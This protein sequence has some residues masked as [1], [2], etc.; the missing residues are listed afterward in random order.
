MAKR[1]RPSSILRKIAMAR[2]RAEPFAPPAAAHAETFVEFVNRVRPGY[3][4]HD[5][6]RKLAAVL[7]D[8]A[9]GK[10]KRVMIFMPPRHSKSETVSRLFSAYYVS[11]FPDRFVGITSYSA[12]LAYTLSRAAKD[13]YLKGGG[14]VRDDVGAVKHWETSHG[15]GMWAAGVGGAITGK[16]FHLGIIDDA[17]KNAEEA[18]SEVIRAKHKEWYG[19]T[20][21][22]REQPGDGWPIVIVQTRWHED[23]LSG[24]LL[25]EEKD[26]DSPEGWHVVCMEAIKEE[27]PPE[28]PPT[29]TLE[30]DGRKPGEPLC[31]AVRP[32]SK[33]KAIAKRI[34]AYAFSALFQQRPTP[35][36]GLMFGT[37]PVV[38]AA[39]RGL[40]KI[41]AWDKAGT[42]G[43]GDYSAGVLIGMTSDPEPEFY[44]LDVLRGQ[45]SSA[46]REKAIKDT[47]SA[48]GH[49]TIIWVEQEPGSGGKHSAEVTIRGLAGYLA[50]AQTASGKGD[51]VARARPLAAQAQVGNVKLVRGEWNRAFIDECKAFPNGKHDDQVD[52]ASLAFVKLC[53][54]PRPD[55]AA[56]A[57]ASPADPLPA[58]G[59][60]GWRMR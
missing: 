52:A 43:G 48:D 40:T 21:Y 34:G 36:D 58:P 26:G 57:P 6:C 35:G 53:L 46:A 60:T 28:L 17:L 49:D 25:S 47:A 24:W 8:V 16:G 20:F 11:R 54:E 56:G 59:G 42:D 30:P 23:D 9:D 55:A 27:M 3:V 50:Y 2:L 12:E 41:R 14:M 51:K 10:K 38:D 45:W 44:V 19:S 29:C 7:Q 15:G 22:T 4:W 32:L 33:L 18:A 5:H 39:P 37:F 1:R 13:N 31:E